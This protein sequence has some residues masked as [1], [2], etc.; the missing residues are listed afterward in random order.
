MK[1]W[2]MA[3]LTAAW[4]SMPTPE[5]EGLLRSELEQKPPDDEKVLA[6][7]HILKD[8][9]RNLPLK[10]SRREEEAWQQYQQ[11][12]MNRKRKRKSPARW[13]SLAASLVLLAALVGSVVPQQA[14]A[15]TFW[16][17]LQ[18]MTSTVLTY[19]SGEGKRGDIAYRFETENPGLQQVYNAAVE[20]GVTEPVVPMWL[21]DGYE[22]T[23]IQV[24]KSPMKT[25]IWVTFGKNDNEIVYKLDVYNGEPAHQYYKDDSHYEKYEQD[26]TAYYVMR[27]NARWTAVWTKDNIEC[28]LTVD[29]QEDTLRRILESIYVMEE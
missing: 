16:E 1:H 4:E 6:L 14:E 27:N 25:G 9:E 13:A 5:L 8:R 24:E 10:L 19:F 21:P 11:K 15:E 26:G 17:M 28:F 22:M 3:D 12:A 18:R 29:C 7:L 23:Q 20:L 2:N